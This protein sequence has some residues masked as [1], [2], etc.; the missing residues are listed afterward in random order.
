MMLR[1]GQMWILDFSIPDNIVFIKIDPQTGLLAREDSK[2]AL[3]E[4]FREGTEPLEYS[5]RD[6]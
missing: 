6:K 3:L 4:A 5:V 1:V 2:E